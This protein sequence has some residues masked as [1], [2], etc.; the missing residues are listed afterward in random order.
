VS[1]AVKSEVTDAAARE[2]IGEIDRIRSSPIE[3]EELSLATSYLDGVFPIRYE[4]TAAI[5]AALANLMV[6]ELPDDYFDRYRENVRAVTRE[7]VLRAAQQHLTPS[8][9]QM[10]IVGD[11]ETVR[12]P[13][14]AIG[15]GPVR[16]YDAQGRLAE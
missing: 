4:T 6:Y 14:A 9:L 1:T 12:G 11:P 13:L 8:A 2:V 5:A 16:V 10:V 15:F 7:Q 3:E